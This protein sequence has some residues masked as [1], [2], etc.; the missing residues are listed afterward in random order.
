MF[1]S[2]LSG[3]VDGRWPRYSISAKLDND[4]T[5]SKSAV[6]FFDSCVPKPN[7]YHPQS[8]AIRASRGTRAQGSARLSAVRAARPDPAFNLSRDTDSRPGNHSFLVDCTG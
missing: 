4:L 5:T 1:L 7:L 3:R 2:S 8:E 6:P